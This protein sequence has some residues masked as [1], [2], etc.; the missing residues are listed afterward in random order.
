[1]TQHS[2]T[3]KYGAKVTGE[4]E[5]KNRFYEHLLNLTDIILDGRRTHI[6]SL[7][8][9][10]KYE[11]LNHQYEAT[12]L[13]IIKPFCKFIKILLSRLIFFML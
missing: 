10:A 5:L 2:L 4:L 9:K 12:R 8:G 3:I 6:E 11:A 7:Q 1:M 13:A